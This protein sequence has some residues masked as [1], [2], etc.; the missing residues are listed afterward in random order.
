MQGPHKIKNFYKG[1][2][3]FDKV[4]DSKLEK[5]FCQ[6]YFQETNIQYI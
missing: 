3:H 5:D 2:C 4:K 6:L 1:D